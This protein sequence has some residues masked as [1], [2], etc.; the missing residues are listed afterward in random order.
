MK[1][2]HITNGYPT[3]NLPEYCI[4]TKDQLD[5]VR[6]MYD[7]DTDFIFINARELG[8]SSYIRAV[9][10]I[11]KM[12][13]SADVIHVF[14]G[15][16]FLL[17]YLCCPRKKIIVSFLNSIENEYQE[18]SYVA[19]LLTYVTKIFIRDKRVFKIFKGSIPDYA[20]ARSYHLPNGVDTE[21]FKPIAKEEAKQRLGLDPGK[22]YI[23]F[24]SS[25][26]LTRSQ[27][28]FDRFASVLNELQNRLPNVEALTVSSVTRADLIL[29]YC[30]SDI[31]LLTSDFEGSPNSVKEALSCNLP[32]VSTDVGNVREMIYGI[33]ACHISDSSEV[34][35]IVELCLDT[36]LNHEN[37]SHNL[38]GYIFSKGLDMKSKTTELYNVYLEVTGSDC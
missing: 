11:V 23:L 3:E 17:V 22:R 20:S 12:S 34:S 7:L 2:L 36:L 8:W 31:H 5:N 18:K 1:V 21:Y 13:R 33:P 16:T 29:Y 9:P 19:S 6:S 4:F 28:R 30:A 35:A 38:R 14:H 15:L 24:V 37:S 26:S 32:V 27:K 25:K 10:K